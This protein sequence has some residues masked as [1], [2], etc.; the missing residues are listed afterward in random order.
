MASNTRPPALHS[1]PEV[2]GAGPMRTTRFRGFVV[3]IGLLLALGGCGGDKDEQAGSTSAGSST[4]APGTASTVAGG[5]GVDAGGGPGGTEGGTGEGENGEVQTGDGQIPEGEGEEGEFPP[6]PEPVDDGEPSPGELPNTPLS[7]DGPTDLQS[8]PNLPVPTTEFVPPKPALSVCGVLPIAEV[9][10]A[11]GLPLEASAEKIE[12][13][14]GECR[15]EKPGAEAVVV[16][17]E[18]FGTSSAAIRNNPAKSNKFTRVKDLG[19][20][21][22]TYQDGDIDLQV[23]QGRFVMYVSVF[24]EIPKPDQEAKAIEVAKKALPL[25]EAAFAG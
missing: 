23:R 8:R 19:N 22:F 10:G 24:A 2:K 20:S 18:D 11:S 6:T 1:G 5:A 15:Y 17:V 4:I 9:A 14:R 3:A 16:S 7:G 13:N 21:A 12:G 25:F